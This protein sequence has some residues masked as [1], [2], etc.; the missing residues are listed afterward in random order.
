MFLLHLFLLL[1]GKMCESCSAGTST[2]WYTWGPSHLNCRLCHNCWQYWKKYGGLKIAS[3]IAD[4]DN[5]ELVKKRASQLV[6]VNSSSSLS[7][8]VV[9]IGGG[10]PGAVAP[11][12]HQNNNND[13]MM[14]M[15]EDRMSD[16]SGRQVQRC[17]IVNCGKEFKLKTHLARHYAQAHGIAIRS[18]SP[19]PIMKTRTA[20]FLQ[21]TLPTK[22][23]RKLCRHLIKPR[24]AARQP[25]YAINTQ[26]VKMECELGRRTLLFPR[27]QVG[28]C[29]L[30]TFCFFSFS[31]SFR[32]FEDSGG[33]EGTA[34]VQEART[35]QCHAQ[36]E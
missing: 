14:M 25:T 21:T 3:R 9:G 22:L 35:R 17:S 36:G 8:G 5:V 4:T 23:S 30:T 13:N 24:K 31:R 33:D 16:M 28:F 29:V 20:F 15:D 32:F 19:R 18:G 7:G 34:R 26:A 27:Y 10:V 1:S 12:H 2:Q 11:N 6:N